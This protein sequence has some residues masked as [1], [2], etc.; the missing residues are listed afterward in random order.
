MNFGVVQLINNLHILPHL[1]ATVK[2]VITALKNADGSDDRGDFSYDI[3]ASPAEP[4][5]VKDGKLELHFRVDR[6]TAEGGNLE[7]LDRVGLS[8]RGIAIERITAS[9]TVDIAKHLVSNIFIAMDTARF[10]KL[11]C[12]VAAFR[13]LAS[14]AKP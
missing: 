11:F 2:K 10:Q 14:P 8:K 4:P 7:K 13:Q 3:V 12:N 5:K 9:R 1:D 6:N